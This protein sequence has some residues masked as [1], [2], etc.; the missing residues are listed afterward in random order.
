[1]PM[2]TIDLN[3]DLGE[4]GSQD[5]ALIALVSSANIACGGHAGDEATMRAAIDACLA[6]GVAVG[7][8]PGY[9]DRE[10]FGRR[11]MALGVAEVTDLVTR[12]LGCFAEIAARAGARVHHVKPHGALYNQAASDPHLAAAVA[13]GLASV[14]PGCR[15]YTPPG[16]VLA[17]AA[18]KAGLPVCAEGFIDRRYAKNGAL[19]SRDQPGAVIAEL[20]MAVAQALQIACEHRVHTVTSSWFPLPAQTLCVHGDSLHAVEIL[21]AVRQAL[22]AAGINLQAP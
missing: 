6:A 2:S 17:D 8:H 1:M 20:G 3:A 4:G 9:E 18:S 22:I 12:Q 13:A 10:H 11:P 19:V 21:R 15:L 14:L 7:A 5:A 16:G